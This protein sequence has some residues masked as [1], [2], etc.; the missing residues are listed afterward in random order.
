MLEQPVTKSRPLSMFRCRCRLAL[1][2]LL[3]GVL[4]CNLPTSAP[5][6]LAPALPLSPTPDADLLRPSQGSVTSPPAIAY[7]PLFEP[8]SCEFPVPSGF[9]PE[10]GYLVVPE[11]RARPDT[12]FIRLHVG[13]FRNRSGIPI[14]TVV[15]L[16]GGRNVRLNLLVSLRRGLGAV[17]ES[18]LIIFD[19]RA[20]AI[21]ALA[22]IASSG[23]M[24]RRCC[25]GGD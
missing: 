1:L 16:S 23:R 6:T 7:Q 15:K 19:Q 22:W 4:A 14:P 2:A 18:D 21:R 10:C 9:S 8:A 5:P 20:S 17:L 13:I 3:S 11:N 12:P 24:S 25:S